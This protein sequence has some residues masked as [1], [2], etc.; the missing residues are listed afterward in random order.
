MQGRHSLVGLDCEVKE[1]FLELVWG[2]TLISHAGC[3]IHIFT[4]P[5]ESIICQ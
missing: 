5:E 4:G 2:M 1:S 3:L